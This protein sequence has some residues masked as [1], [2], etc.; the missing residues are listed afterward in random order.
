LSLKLRTIV[1]EY[2]AGPAVSLSQWPRLTP[3]VSPSRP[4]GCA[5]AHAPGSPGAPA[6]CQARVAWLSRPNTVKRESTRSAT[7]FV[8][9]VAVH[10]SRAS[11]MSFGSMLVQVILKVRSCNWCPAS[12][13]NEGGVLRYCWSRS[14]ARAPTGAQPPGLRNQR[15]GH[16]CSSA[17]GRLWLSCCAHSQR[18]ATGGAKACSSQQTMKER[19]ATAQDPETLLH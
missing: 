6:Q 15:R 1:T 4:G 12:T 13:A 17:S 2:V 3:L 16:C 7:A 10:A 19:A 8:M 14:T 11:L 9:P 5:H 18:R